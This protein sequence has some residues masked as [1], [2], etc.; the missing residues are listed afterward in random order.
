LPAVPQSRLLR[1]AD[2]E[3]LDSEGLLRIHY[4]G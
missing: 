2:P 3:S 4:G 1:L